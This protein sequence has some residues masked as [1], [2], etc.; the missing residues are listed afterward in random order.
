M[1]NMRFLKNILRSLSLTILVIFSACTEKI[2][3]N[4]SSS[5]TRLVV[6]GS[7]STDTAIQV[8]KLTKSSEFFSTE[9]APAVSG[10]IVTVSDGNNIFLL[11]EN[12]VSKGSYETSSKVAGIIGKTYTLSIS[13]VDING[14]GV[15]EEYHA[16]S[17]LRS[18]IPADSLQIAREKQPGAKDTGWVV[19]VFAKN[20]QGEDWFLFKVKKNQQQL[21][22]SAH[23]FTSIAYSDGSQ[24]YISGSAVFVSDGTRPEEKLKSGDTIT[25]EA[26]GITKEYYQFLI[27]FVSEY[28]PKSPIGSGPSSNISTNIEP[29]DKAVGFFTAYSVQRI[30]II[31]KPV[32]Q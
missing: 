7:F 4:L 24:A 16:Q 9:V 25:L 6:D 23:K 32:N 17:E 30:S 14:D 11:N 1:N 29:K 27:D 19:K 15:M 26:L 31:Y 12:P 20:V 21:S 28:Y 10:A 8:V 3:L 2:N 5:Y 22:D 18:V 13:N